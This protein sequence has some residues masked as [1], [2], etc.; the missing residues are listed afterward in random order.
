MS[1]V[2]WDS[3]DI[4]ATLQTGLALYTVVATTVILKEVRESHL[5]R[6]RML[7]ASRCAIY[8]QLI[9]LHK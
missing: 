7:G 3:V 6:T 1:L 8:E 4:K 9:P 5:I 2:D